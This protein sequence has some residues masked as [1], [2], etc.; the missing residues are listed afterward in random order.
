MDIS[1]AGDKFCSDIESSANKLGEMNKLVHQHD[2][3]LKEN[4]AALKDITK[5]SC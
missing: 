1:F 5:L 3:E 4:S 2:T